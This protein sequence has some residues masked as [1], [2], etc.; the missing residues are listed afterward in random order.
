MI[1]E[2][3]RALEQHSYG[4]S[5]DM[6]ST[7]VPKPGA[8]EVLVKVVAAGVDRGTWHLMAGLPYVVRLGTGLRGPRRAVPG[9]D[10]AG[11][12]AAVGPGVTRFAVGDHVLGIGRGAFADYAVAPQTKLVHKPGALGFAQAAALPIS[13]LTAL[14]AVVDAGHVQQ[15]DKVLVLGAS[16]GVGSF[17]TQIA[18]AAGAEVTGVCSS[19]KADLVRTLGA[20]RVLAYDDGGSAAPGEYDLIIDVGGRRPVRSLRRLLSERGTLVIVGGEGGGRIAGGVGRQ[21][22][23]ALLSPFV[24]QRLVVMMARERATDLERLVS[25][26][27]SGELAPAVERAFALED[28]SEAVGYVADGRARGKVVVGVGLSRPVGS[29]TFS[30][31]SA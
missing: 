11:T 18:K 17:A 30:E 23:A 26:V 13:G 14:Q 21:I 7:A 25:L 1:P 15:G 29:G 16:G 8:G 3:M 5:A 19:A 31:E 20:D 12:V 4:T 22:R 27:E 2:T 28:A 6:V 10:L 9:R 24:G